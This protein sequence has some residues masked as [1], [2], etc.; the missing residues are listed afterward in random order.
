MSKR[1]GSKATQFKPGVSG[2]PGG[3]TAE[4]IKK[5]RENR[6]KAFAIEEKL[7]NALSKD[8]SK[9]E[10]DVINHIRSDVLKLI[11]TAIERFDGKATQPIDNTS[12]DGS[13]SPTK[14]E[15]VAVGNDSAD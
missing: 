1:I 15:I 2:N 13:M 7:L 14:I 8:I 9:N 12:S 4:Q 11:H 6:D 5:R 10:A 3:L